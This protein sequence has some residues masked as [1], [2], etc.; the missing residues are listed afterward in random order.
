MCHSDVH[1]VRGEWAQP[2]W[3][4]M[5]PGHEVIGVVKS[6]GANV[7]KFKAGD[8]VGV[9]CM[10]DSCG[11]CSECKDDLEQHCPVMDQTYN[12]SPSALNGESMET[13]IE[14]AFKGGYSKKIV[15]K[16]HFVVS[17]PESIS[18]PEKFPFAAPLLCA[19]IT[20]YSPLA[21]AG[22]LKG[23]MKVGVAGF[24]GLGHMAVKL[25]IAMGNEVTVLSRGTA[26]AEHAK[27]LGAQYID[28]KDA[29]AVA[30]GRKSLDVIVNTI[31]A[32]HVHMGYLSLLRTGG[33]MYVVGVPPTAVDLHQVMLIFGRVGIIGSLIGGMK[34]TQEMMDFCGKHGIVADGD[35]IKPEECNHKIDALATGTATASRYV[36]DLQELT[37]DTVV[38]Q[39]ELSQV[40]A[41]HQGVNAGA[42]IIN[43][44][45]E[46]F[47]AQGPPKETPSTTTE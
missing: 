35:I 21:R 39:L 20:S 26:K 7:T 11:S 3:Y 30:A 33:N 17:I 12:D 4:P 6:V 5:V 16:E 44:S 18:T 45:K 23:G 14:A 22:C 1:Q 27:K 24:G 31:P 40:A 19:G 36:V 2:V 15:V 9:G 25:A 29:D 43:A 8:K 47:G 42:N 13:R 10:V 34:E 38:E 28:M 32:W 37:A 46:N 41:S